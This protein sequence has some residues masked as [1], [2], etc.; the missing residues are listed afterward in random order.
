MKG[1]MG[2]YHEDGYVAAFKQASRFAGRKGTIGT[3]PDVTDSRLATKPGDLPWEAYYTTLSAEFLGKSKGGTQILI[4]AHGIGP[5]ATLDG[6]LKAYSYHFNDKERN[7]RGGRISQKEFLELESGKYGDVGIV[8]FQPILKRYQYPFLEVL[9]L[10]Q[11]LD[12]PLLAARLGPRC[13][14]YLERHAGF[15]REWHSVQMLLHRENKYGLSNWKEHMK[16]RRTQHFL[17]SVPDSNPYII[18]MGYPSNCSY[19][20]HPPEDGLALAHRKAILVDC[21]STSRRLDGISAIKD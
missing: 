4:V 7:R 21:L 1:A 20:N 19:T 17:G 3:M 18:E 8:E 2:F 13:K 16:D 6:V 11:A 9:T 14:E 10:R 15:A 12:E 5:M